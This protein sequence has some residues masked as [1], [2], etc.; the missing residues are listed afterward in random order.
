MTTVA[1]RVFEDPIRDLAQNAFN[2]R[3][4]LLPANGIEGT[5]KTNFTGFEFGRTI[6]AL[7]PKQTAAVASFGFAR[8]PE[9]S[10]KWLNARA[11]TESR[12]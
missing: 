7:P 2:A 8:L 5:E 3:V 9:A 12:L 4:G 6:P 10:H 1:I 11:R